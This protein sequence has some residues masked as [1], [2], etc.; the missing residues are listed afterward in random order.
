MLDELTDDSGKVNELMYDEFGVYL[1]LKHVGER[2]A[3][4]QVVPDVFK[5][6]KFVAEQLDLYD[7]KYPAFARAAGK[8]Y[9]YNN[10]LLEYAR[11]YGLVSADTIKKWNDMYP[12]H[13]TMTRYFGSH[14]NEILGK[15]RRGARG[16]ANQSSPY[17]R[18]HGGSKLDYWN[19]LDVAMEETARVIR[20][21]YMNHVMQEIV[22]LVKAFPD[23]AS[24]MENIPLNI[25]VESVGT[26][27]IKDMLTDLLVSANG[28]NAM[29]AAGIID[30][31]LPDRIFEYNQYAAS[32]DEKRIV[33]VMYGGKKQMWKVNDESLYK[34]LVNLSNMG[35]ESAPVKM[36]H[37]FTRVMTNFLTAKNP[38]FTLSNAMRD[39]GTATFKL[40]SAGVGTGGNRAKVLKAFAK[41]LLDAYAQAGKAHKGG[42]NNASE[43]YR[44]YISLK[45]ADASL[46]T[47][48]DRTAKEVVKEYNSLSTRRIKPRNAKE[49]FGKAG[50][51]FTFFSFI[52][53]AVEQSPRYALYVTARE[54]GYAPQTALRM[55]EQFTNDFHQGGVISKQI[56][57]AVPFFNA[58]MQ[59]LYENARHNS[60]FAYATD[61]T[62]QPPTDKAREGRA[63]NRIAIL[64]S[65]SAAIA[66]IEVLLNLYRKDDYNRL[67]NYVKNNY[68]CIPTANG[69]FITVPKPREWAVSETLFER[70]FES[71]L[72]DNDNALD[73]DDTWEY[74]TDM[75][76]PSGIASLAQGDVGGML[77]TFGVFGTLYEVGANKDFLGRPIVSSAYENLSAKNQYNGGTSVL[78]WALGQATDISPLKIDHI[79]ENL[80]GGAW[81]F[82]EAMF[83]MSSSERD[84]SMGLANKYLKDSAYSQ[85]IVNRMYELKGEAETAKADDPED[86]D[87]AID[88]KWYNTVSSFYSKYYTLS[89]SE[90]ESAQK[91]ATRL[92][93]LDI[94]EGM[95]DVKSGSLYAGQEQLE[96][97]VKRS[98]N[99]SVMPAVMAST[100]AYGKGL[101][102]SL[103]LT[104]DQYVTYQTAYNGYYWDNVEQIMSSSLD[105]DQLGTALSVAR[106]DALVSA[107]NDMLKSAG[108]DASET[109]SYSA[110]KACGVS[111]ADYA[112]V[113]EYKNSG[114]AKDSVVR[115][116]NTLNITDRKKTA[117]YTS[118]GYSESGL[119]DT[120]WFN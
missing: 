32:N 63:I 15:V 72:T 112:K 42:V 60:G 57:K 13:V 98:G 67:S 118:M 61:D 52:G 51:A 84:W 74:V 49:A 95:L 44:E 86:A 48:G 65:L 106:D 110:A 40:A 31:I 70:A 29:E 102:E 85:D 101:S 30:S 107:K 99:T 24:I 116:I 12:H 9:D 7:A 22:D 3:Q 103:S 16:Y 10:T 83:P 58:A 111:I 92:K 88:Y 115:Y 108:K 64:L 41:N 69:K 79:G 25:N 82:V 46:Y 23:S 66:L 36:L 47:K 6:D 113:K 28:K 114:N 87:A 62:V 100:I 34:I 27:K 93:V 120:P 78:A 26:T 50:K 45:G 76:L 117:L 54:L 37:A 14:A 20:A 8:F 119:K 105:D 96:A 2:K 35:K 19:G 89:K 38:F 73:K 94:I 1:I 77:G 17:K 75:L 18:T 80:L 11:M 4:G 56:N 5:D 39:L 90:N 104:A 59:G 109:T 71:L 81:S 91:R 55:S 68:Y 43:Y 97:Y 21:A 53:N 33:T